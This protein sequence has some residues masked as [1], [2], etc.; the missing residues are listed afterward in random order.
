MKPV[1]YSP[2][3]RFQN[4]WDRLPT[5]YQAWLLHKGFELF[6]T[7]KDAHVLLSFVLASIQD[8]KTATIQT[9]RHLNSEGRKSVLRQLLTFCSPNIKAIHMQMYRFVGHPR[10][11]FIFSTLFTC[12]Q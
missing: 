10:K 8:P 3:R 6:D 4:I 1:Y 2:R 9:P 7:R 12:V 5:K 11:G